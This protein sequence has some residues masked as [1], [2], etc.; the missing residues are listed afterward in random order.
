M[1]YPDKAIL[2]HFIAEDKY[3]VFASFYGGYLGS[4]SWRRSSPIQKFELEDEI[5]T[6]TTESGNQY[7]FSLNGLGTSGYAQSVLNGALTE[8]VNKN[9]K[10]L[11]TKDE[12]LAVVEKFSK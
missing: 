10:L 8:D 4:D 6:A 11:G 3:S 7:K 1:E 12:V 9:I 5:V 2:M